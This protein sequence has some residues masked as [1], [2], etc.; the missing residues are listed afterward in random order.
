[1]KTSN[2][3]AGVYALVLVAALAGIHLCHGLLRAANP[4]EFQALTNAFDAS[5]SLVPYVDF[6]DNHGP[7][8]IWVLQPVLTLWSGGHELIYGLRGVA[9]INTMLLTGMVF[10]MVRRLHPRRFVAPWIATVFLLTAPPFLS[11]A[12]EIRGD[13][14]ANLLATIALAILITALSKRKLILFFAVGLCLGVMAGLTLKALIAAAALAV[15]YVCWH[16]RDK[17]VPH[18]AGLVALAAGTTIALFAIILGLV[19]TSSLPAFIN[20]Y[21]GGNIARDSA[22]FTST[23]FV[24]IYKKAPMWALLAT[25]VVCASL[26]RAIRGRA[27]GVEIGFLGM[28]LFYVAQ[29]LLLIP[30]KNMQSLLPLYAPLALLTPYILIEIENR[31]WLRS[32]R[33][34]VAFAALL[35]LALLRDM[36]HYSNLRNHGLPKQVTFSN[37]VLDRLTHQKYIFDPTGI[38]FLKR[39]PGS[40]HVLVTYIRQMHQSGVIDLQIP[41]LL[42]KNKVEAIIFDRRTKDLR[43]ADV[44]YITANYTPILKGPNSLLL[45]LTS[46]KTTSAKISDIAPTSIPNWAD[47]AFEDAKEPTES[48]SPPN[49]YRAAGF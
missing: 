34:V 16:V 37:Q 20:C 9:W 32:K 14:P 27:D 13:N 23:E 28:T 35:P 15:F 31:N 48:Y 7:L 44:A 42:T 18:A 5:R 36:A 30:T 21:F 39:K 1:M 26:W 29:F 43:T 38:V 8:M 17:K 19:T 49:W 2:K 41:E 12:I 25:F 4:D 45:T 22:G 11:K 40:F 46:T 3:K 6:W 47:D 10:W 24:E 33:I